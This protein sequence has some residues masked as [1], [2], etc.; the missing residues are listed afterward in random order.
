MNRRIS[1]ATTSLFLA[2]LMAV[3]PAPSWAQSTST[4]LRRIESQLD[5]LANQNASLRKQVSDQQ[6]EIEQLRSELHQTTAQVAPVTAQIPAI[7]QDL[8]QQKVLS[9]QVQ[10]LGMM[11]K[12]LNFGV[13]FHTGWAENPY[14]MP[15]GFFYG[16]Y[17][18]HLLVSEEDGL[19]YG[20]L[21]GELMAG[22]T[23]GS[24]VH[25]S[26]NLAST[27][28]AIK[29]PAPTFM[30]NFELEPTLQYHLDMHAVGLERLR[31]LEPYILGGPGIWMPMMST[32]VTVQGNIP[33]S[34]FRHDDYTV[35]AG[36]V[37]GLGTEIRVGELITI[38]TIQG[39]LDRL[40]L[41]A[42]W[43]YNWLANGQQFQQY[44]G[45]LG[46]GL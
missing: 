25:T 39:I 16:A 3:M 36:A 32:P 21:T 44:T 31:G 1:I 14:D 37:W 12:R 24:S 28:G 6:A 26:A 23:T 30:T 13:G 45:Q 10:D 35:D 38:P 22:I 27:L 9:Q 33:G 43:R 42:E 41:G 15:G 29:G 46:F 7:R 17:I 11:A 18:N 5:S 20:N 19:P 2:A 40:T 4:R 34:G 8:A